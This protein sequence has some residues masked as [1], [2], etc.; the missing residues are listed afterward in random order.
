MY[1]DLHTTARLNELT[2]SDSPPLQIG[3]H[4][5]EPSDP[6]LIKQLTRVL[7]ELP[8]KQRDA[9]LMSAA[10][11]DC[12][13]I[14]NAQGMSVGTVRSRIHYGRAKARLQLAALYS[15]K[16]RGYKNDKANQ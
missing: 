15:P 3:A 9:L 6:E 12:A 2:R 13:D 10:G 4:D 1:E 7:S 16:K 11:S 8:V 14:A 5:P